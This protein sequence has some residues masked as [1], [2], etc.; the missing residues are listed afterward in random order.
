MSL[1]Y[2]IPPTAESPAGVIAT[3]PAR[4]KVYQVRSSFFRLFHGRATTAC[5]RTLKELRQEKKNFFFYSSAMS[6]MK[7]AEQAWSER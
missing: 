5:A 1:K 4:F 2:E 7:A 3:V 6:A